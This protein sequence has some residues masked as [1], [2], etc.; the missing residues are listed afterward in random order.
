MDCQSGVP[1][2]SLS[3]ACSL[4]ANL[5]SAC[6][7]LGSASM[8]AEAQMKIADI[9]ELQVSAVTTFWNFACKLQKVHVRT[10]SRRRSRGALQLIQLS[11]T[12]TDQVART[13]ADGFLWQKPPLIRNVKSQRFSN[14]ARCEGEVLRE[15]AQ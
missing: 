4:G 10:K 9:A 14:H 1:L 7:A 6:P 5:D 13:S 8:W 3:F 15:A 12:V 2:K 11:Q